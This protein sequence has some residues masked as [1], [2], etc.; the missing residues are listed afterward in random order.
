[1]I[2]S[3]MAKQKDPGLS[4]R[5]AETAK[6]RRSATFTRQKSQSVVDERNNKSSEEHKGV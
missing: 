2:F 4:R 5:P 1:M 6:I 3:T